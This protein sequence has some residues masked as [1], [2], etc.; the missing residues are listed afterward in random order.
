VILTAEAQD[1][2]K[3]EYQY[4]SGKYKVGGDWLTNLPKTREWFNKRLGRNNILST[5]DT[6]VS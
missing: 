2:D 5:V 4:I 6:P 1:V 3:N